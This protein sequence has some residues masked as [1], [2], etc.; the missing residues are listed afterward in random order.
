MLFLSSCLGTNP[1]KRA[2]P[3]QTPLLNTNQLATYSATNTHSLNT[4]SYPPSIHS[5][6]TTPDPTQSA[7]HPNAL[8]PAVDTGSQAQDEVAGCVFCGVG[9]KPGFDIVYQVSFPIRL[10]PLGRLRRPAVNRPRLRGRRLTLASAVPLRPGPRLRNL[11]RPEPSL[12]GS[13]TR[14]P[15]EAHR[16]RQSP[17]QGR[18]P[19]RFVT[20]PFPSPS[21]RW[22]HTLCLPTLIT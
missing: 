20:S 14:C 2:I 18:P 8:G 10:Q 16:Q 21:P 13:P 6:T 3:D 15:K 22:V 4:T 17:S 19:D 5:L 11:P 12:E 9:D 1:S 7:A